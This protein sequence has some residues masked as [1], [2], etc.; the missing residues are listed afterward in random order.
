MRQLPRT[1]APPVT[2]TAPDLPALIRRQ[3]GDS[4]PVVVRVIARLNV[5][6]PAIHVSHLTEGLADS[7]P[8][9]LVTGLVGPDEGDMLPEARERG[10]PIVVI[11]E[12]GRTVRPWQDLT[13]LRKLVALFRRLRPTI[14]HTHTA[15]AGTLGRIAAL[16]TRVPVRVH[17]FHGHVLRGYFRSHVTRAV[18]ATERI[19]AR[20]THC[21]VTVSEGQ[22]REL[23]EEFRVCPREKIA[24]VPLGLDLDPY[25][26]ASIEKTRGE[27]RAELGVGGEPLVTIVGRLVP[28]KNHE[29]FL[30][31]AAL[32]TARGRACTYVIVGGGEEEARLRRLASELGIAERVRFLGW[33]GDLP[34]IY[35][36]SDVVVL[37]SDNEGTPVSII[38]ALASGCAVAATDVGGVRDV[39]DGGRL[40][41]LVPAGDAERLADAV[42]QLLDD[43]GKR[44]ELGALG[45]EE[46]PRRYSRERLLRDMAALYDRLLAE[47]GLGRPSARSPAD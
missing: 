9:V 19:L 37:T 23:A 4:R 3:T 30:R 42:A 34:A 12:L 33:R 38:E 41:L 10:L 16:V 1:P 24:I 8:T 27:L 29:L 2:A 5:G 35:A 36:D 39:L 7:Y 21:I 47:R 17:T 22:A 6:G 13:A 28:I 45:R 31:M 11:P 20:H 25:R 44:S 14:V 46:V 26:L 18:I 32:L 15:K 43:P 40:G